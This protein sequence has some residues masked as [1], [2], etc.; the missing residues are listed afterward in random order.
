M[1]MLKLVLQNISVYW[2]HHEVILN[3]ESIMNHLLWV[4]SQLQDKIHLVCWS[5]LARP[6]EEGGWGFINT[7]TFNKELIIK[8][9]W[10]EVSRNGV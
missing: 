4:G 2:M 7:S 5:T 8:N 6:I 10:R 3:I 9:M 1:I